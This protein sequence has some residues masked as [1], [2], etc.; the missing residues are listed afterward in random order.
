MI[1]SRLS[2]PKN[3]TNFDPFAEFKINKSLNFIL[4]KILNFE[5]LLIKYNI[6]FPMGG[7]LLMIAKKY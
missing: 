6:N 7:S 4:E 3:K 2:Q 5:R 1:L